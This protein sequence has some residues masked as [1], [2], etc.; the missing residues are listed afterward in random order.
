MSKLRQQ[1]KAF[2][3]HAGHLGGKKRAQ[4][5]S[6]AR[7]A[8]IA[9]QAA[10]ARWG[11]SPARAPLQPS[12]RL[13]QIQWNDP[14]YLE[15]VLSEGSLEIWREL[16]KQIYDFPFGATAQILKKVLNATK[17][18]G[19]TPLWKGILMSVQGFPDEKKE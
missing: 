10:R 5:L 3:E 7:R 1:S 2:F 17:I 12:T 11:K 18:Y 14:V 6:A 9:S 13:S 8:F 15:E 4:R 19:I 16:Y